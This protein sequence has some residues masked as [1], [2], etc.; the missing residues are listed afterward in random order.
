MVLKK[1]RIVRDTY[2]GYEVQTWR[3]WFP[4]WLQGATNTH[5]TIEKAK[6]YIKN[7]KNKVVY[8]EE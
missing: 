7:L 1:Y 2:S 5:R 4:F 8:Y 6:E 3:L